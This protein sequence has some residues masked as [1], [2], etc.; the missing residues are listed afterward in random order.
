MLGDLDVVRFAAC[1]C[2]IGESPVWNR[3][4]NVLLWTDIDGRKVYASD[5]NAGS[6][7]EFSVPGRVGAFC[8]IEGASWSIILAAIEKTIA[9]IDLESAKSIDLHLGPLVGAGARLN[10]GRV[11]GDGNFVFGA[12]DEG[13][14]LPS[15]GLWQLS[16]SGVLAQLAEGL[17]CA[18]SICFSPDGNYLYFV[19]SCIGELT[20]AVYKASPAQI[21]SSRIM[22]QCKPGL[23]YFDGSCVDTDG[24]IWTAIWGGGRIE[25][26]NRDGGLMAQFAVPVPYPTSCSFGGADHDQLFITTARAGMSEAQLE[27]APDSGSIFRVRPGVRGAVEKQFKGLE[28]I[29]NG[30]FK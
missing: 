21:L 27:L 9:I 11:D 22:V 16:H 12:M 13:E 15:G 25:S 20:R 23:D 7:R 24:N 29:N 2:I 4:H 18:N 5:N 19:D 8:A 14:K 17:I 28:L 10:D 30:Q 3:E 6:F 1:R 26:R